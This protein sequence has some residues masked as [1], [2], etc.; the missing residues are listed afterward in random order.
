MLRS[1]KFLQMRHF[2]NFASFIDFYQNIVIYHLQILYVTDNRKHTL[3]L[4]MFIFMIRN[5]DLWTSSIYGHTSLS[6]T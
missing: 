4:S 2:Q 3:K 5:I 1:D 6:C